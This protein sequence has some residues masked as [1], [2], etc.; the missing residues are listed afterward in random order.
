MEQRPEFVGQP[1]RGTKAELLQEAPIVMVRKVSEDVSVIRPMQPESSDVRFEM[2]GRRD[3]RGL[4]TIM[5]MSGSFRGR[6]VLTNAL[7]EPAFLLF[8]CR[9]PRTANDPGGALLAGGLKLN[10]PA[11]GGQENTKDAWVWSG[12]LEPHRAAP[13]EISYQVAALQAATYRVGEQNGNPVKRLRV[14]FDRKDLDSMRFESGDGLKDAA[15]PSVTWE[16]QDFLA[17]DFFSATILE[18]RNLHVSLLQLVQIGPL[19]CLLF[20]LT[21]SAAILARQ[22]LTGLQMLTIAAGYAFYFPLIVYLSARFRFAVA[23]SIAVVVP[24]A[25]L[26][27]YSRWLLGGWRGLL[28]AAV[29]LA[30]FW[31]FPTL[32]AF[33]GWNRGMVLLC[34]GVV[35]LWVL[36]NL[37]NRAL[38]QRRALAAILLALAAPAAASAAEVQ[39]VVPAEIADKLLGTSRAPSGAIVAFQPVQYR[40]WHE[41]NRIR[42]EARAALNCLRPGEAPL[43]LFSAPVHLLEAGVES[44]LTNQISVL[45]VSNRLALLAAAPGNAI[46]RISYRV[47]VEP[48]EGKNRAQIPLL[49]VAPATVRLESTRADLEILTGSLWTRNSAENTTVYEVGIAGEEQLVMEWSEAAGGVLPGGRTGDLAK[50]FYGIGLTRAQHLTVVN[51]DGSCVHFAEVELPA[52]QAEEFRIKLPE[53]T[54]LISV[55]VNGSELSSP[56]VEA[57]VCRV[58]L[59]AREAQQ[60]VYRLSFRLAYPPLRLGFTGSTELLLPEVFLTTGT[61]DWVVA[62]PS[63]FQTQVISSG[64]ELQKSAPD[65]SRF[66][67]YGRVLKSHAVTYLS[68]DLAPPG[69]VGLSLK[70]RQLVPGL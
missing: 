5:D 22:P 42:A 58:R 1:L 14:T 23:M 64:L 2:S 37:Q 3:Y 69:Q 68:K 38:R 63:G 48:R 12:T 4:R 16:R 53:K 44:D 60:S 40:V 36:I 13:I 18:S 31:V 66:G 19:V 47:P 11:D 67:D 45:T 29:V 20:L 24:G 39:V 6:Y 70:Y 15:G 51:S 46:L 65:L 49:L 10:A 34:L 56:I 62:L 26:V 27:N 61:V 59:P 41:T 43:P 50:G 54:R 30:L 33:A 17:P 28:A 32:A 52:F 57:Q 25:L 7:D 21:I 9:H 35:T 55:S 8:A